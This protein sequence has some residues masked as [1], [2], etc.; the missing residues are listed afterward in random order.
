MVK[1]TTGASS[2]SLEEV[3]ERVERNVG[4]ALEGFSIL[5]VKVRS[6]GAKDV[7]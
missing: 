5:R 3:H 1:A 4:T 7:A 6:T 2:T